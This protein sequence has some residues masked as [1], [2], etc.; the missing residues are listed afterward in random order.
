MRC[1]SCDKPNPPDA[2][3]CEECGAALKAG[4]PRRRPESEAIEE[5]PSRR[6]AA[7][8]REA[9][10]ARRRPDDD[11]D[12]EDDRPRRRRRPREE[13]DEGI[14]TLIPYKN[15]TA[16]VSY[17][18]GVFSLIPGL[19]LVLAP[20]SIILGIIGLWYVRRNPKSHGTGHAITGIVLSLITLTLNVLALVIYLTGR[21][22]ELFRTN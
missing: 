8:H 1:P 5:R 14:A 19:A 10:R 11:D 15:P 9:P 13:S 16:L 6:P 21:W 12:D 20:V 17:Y 3:R 4:P 2:T 7:D 18:C 22:A